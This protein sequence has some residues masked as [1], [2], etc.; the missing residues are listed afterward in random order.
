MV[1]QPEPKILI[2]HLFPSPQKSPAMITLKTVKESENAK[3][4]EK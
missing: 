2:L 4:S 1:S 3:Y